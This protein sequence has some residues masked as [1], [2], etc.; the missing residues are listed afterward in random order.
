MII[1][2]D[3]KNKISFVDGSLPKPAE[4]SSD[5]RAWNRCSNMVKGWITASLKRHVAKGIMYFKTATAIW[6]DLEARFGNP[7]SSQIYRL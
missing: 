7:S 6:N 1:S 3:A 5:E 2:L 4:G